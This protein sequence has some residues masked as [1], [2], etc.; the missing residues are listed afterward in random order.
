MSVNT[1]RNPI[2]ALLSRP[3]D[4]AEIERRLR[5]VAG[6]VPSI[7]A[8]L[9][10]P[11]LDPASAATLA[12]PVVP[13]RASRELPRL[14]VDLRGTLDARESQPPPTRGADLEVR[15]VIGEGGMGRV[16][17]AHQRSL[18]RDVAVKTTKDGAPEVARAALLAEGAITGRLEHPSIVPV[19]ALGVDES[20]RP[21]LVMK[22]IEGTSWLSLLRDPAHDGWEGWEGTALDRLPGH[23]AILSMIANAV[24]FAHSRGVVHRDIKPENVLIGRFGDVYLADWG[25]AARIGDSDT[26]LSGTPGYMAPEMV[27]GRPVDARTDVYLLGATLHE[28]LVGKLRHESPTALGALVSARRSLPFEYPASVP[29]ELAELANQACH[30]EPERRPESAKAFRDSLTRYVAH[31]Q[32]LA[33]ASAALERVERLEALAALKE[34]TDTQRAEMDR[35]AAEAQFGLDQAVSEWPG[36]TRAMDALAR[37]TRL[38]EARRARSAELERAARERDPTVAWRARALALS[39]MAAGAAVIVSYAIASVDTPSPLQLVMLP[40]LMFAVMSSGTLLFRTRI[41]RTEFNRQLVLALHLAIALVLVGRV[42]GLFTYIEPAA[43]FARDCFA[44]A[45]VLGVT[46]IALL[47]WA[48][49]VSL[50]YLAG[51][52]VCTFAPEHAVNA[53]GISSISGVG[54]AAALAWRH[55]GG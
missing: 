21:A 54:L 22:R 51:G 14:S 38:L 55:R 42:A 40:A 28:I 3:V 20:G 17:L 26:A 46:S 13:A 11:S 34:P 48:G 4:E 6:P 52:M 35:L 12:A 24:H 37:L 44:I 9:R 27:I 36:N 1:P 31:R 30:V 5:D 10:R 50:V 16:F 18:D 53:F 33:L 32:S 45:G 25:V 7:A 15:G 49:W 41:L 8:T 29:A 39:F 43:H 19:H 23:L 2:R 47:R